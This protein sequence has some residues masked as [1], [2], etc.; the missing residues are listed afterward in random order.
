MH[1]YMWGPASA[2]QVMNLYYMAN[3]LDDNIWI[4]A[5]KPC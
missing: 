4:H 5:L 1:T 3:I 2:H